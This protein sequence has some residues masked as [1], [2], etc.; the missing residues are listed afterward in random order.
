VS[1]PLVDGAPADPAPEPDLAPEPG[2]GDGA[3][4]LW[5]P[6]RAWEHATGRRWL[7]GAS[8]PVAVWML[9]RVGQLALSV[10]LGG[11]NRGFTAV[12]AAFF[13]DGER[14]LQITEHGYVQAAQQMPNTAFFP[15][16]SWLAWPVWRVTHSEVWTGHLVATVTGIAAFVAVWGVTRAWQDEAMAR[17]AVWLL[18]LFPSSLFLWAFYSEGLFIALGAGAVWADRRDRRGIAA[19]CLFALATTRSVGV[20]VALVL[21]LA[22]VVHGRRL[23]RWVV[24]YAA[25]A[26]AGL[27]AVMG[28]MG[29]YTDDPLAFMSVQKDWGRALSLP[30][31]TVV[32]GFESLWPEPSTIMVPA[33]VARNFD[34][35][36]LLIVGIAIA[37][38]AFARSEGFPFESWALGLA[39]IAL[40][41]CSTSLASFNRFVMADWV[42][43]PAYASM[44]GRLPRPW[45]ALVWSGVVI[46]TVITTYHMVG[47]FSVDRFVG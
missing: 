6:V 38:L 14:Y 12:N 23:D 10:Y 27:G 43:Y 8:Y 20:L 13:Y 21:A 11:A 7:P 45:R 35:W 19:L 40:P 30:W 33:L 16:V 15:G 39:L 34:L 3:P 1:A 5:R 26:L 18:A 22:R 24:A 28:V 9:W 42:I 47:R 32:N 2:A 46:A 41:L 17:R 31:V 36:C 25:A 4:R 29:Y 37:W 44:L